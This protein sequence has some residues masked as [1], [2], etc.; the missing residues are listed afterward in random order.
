MREWNLLAFFIQPYL[1]LK[2]VRESQVD[3][4]GSSSSGVRARTG[5]NQSEKENGI[6]EEMRKFK[7]EILEIKGMEKRLEEK[8]SGSRRRK[9]GSRRRKSGSRRS[10]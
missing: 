10:G 2:A 5:M 9:I 3:N 6:E 7:V 4:A 8:E 1:V